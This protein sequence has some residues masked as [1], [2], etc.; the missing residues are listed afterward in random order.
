MWHED[1]ASCQCISGTGCDFAEV[2]AVKAPIDI[3]GHIYSTS[4]NLTQ[5]QSVI[6]LSTSLWSFSSITQWKYC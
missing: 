2:P 1:A 6:F 5:K 3:L 4:T